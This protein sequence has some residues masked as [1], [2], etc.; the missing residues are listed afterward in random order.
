[1]AGQDRP[2]FVIAQITVTDAKAY[3]SYIAKVDET[4]LIYDGRF[5][6]RGGA[7][8]S[9]EGEPAGER[10][11][12]IKFPTVNAAHAWYHSSAYAPVKK[13]RQAASNSVQTIVQG[14]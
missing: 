2:G 5:L 10:F 11:V 7:A 1:V 3:E 9:F 13:L 12:V 8:Q 14:I 4:L 6:V